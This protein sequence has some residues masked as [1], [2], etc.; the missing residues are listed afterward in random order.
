MQALAIE[1]KM[2]SR[3]NTKQL[4]T[5]DMLAVDHEI[6]CLLIKTLL[7]VIPNCFYIACYRHIHV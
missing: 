2:Y 3:D 6:V 7:H 1:M 4:D 5:D